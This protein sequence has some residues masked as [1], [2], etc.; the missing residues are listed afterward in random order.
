MRNLRKF[1]LPLSRSSSYLR[2]RP[3][4]DSQS[5][6]LCPLVGLQAAKTLRITATKLC[7]LQIADGV[8]P[9]VYVVCPGC[10]LVD[11]ATFFYVFLLIDP[12]YGPF[13]LV[14]MSKV[15]QST[16]LCYKYGWLFRI[17]FCKKILFLSNH[18]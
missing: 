7:K 3:V 18:S 15:G 4:N 2:Q 8:I 9:F 1:S 11:P 13:F 14:K 17:G 10:F 5:P 6:F 12:F 16:D